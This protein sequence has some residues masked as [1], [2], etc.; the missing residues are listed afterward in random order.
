MSDL[1]HF[2]PLQSPPAAP[3]LL[4]SQTNNPMILE[5]YHWYSVFL[6]WLCPFS[7]SVVILLSFLQLS[8]LDGL[9]NLTTYCWICHS[10]RLDFYILCDF[11]A[12]T[13]PVSS[14]SRTTFSRG[15][16]HE[17]CIWTRWALASLMT[18]VKK[19]NK[20]AFS[21]ITCPTM[22]RVRIYDGRFLILFSL[23]ISN[24]LSIRPLDNCNPLC[25]M[26]VSIFSV[27]VI[28]IAFVGKH[29]CDFFPSILSVFGPH[30][31]RIPE[32]PVHGCN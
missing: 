5:K 9:I 27:R 3:S 28:Q 31:E 14:T 21:H 30:A 6:T 4:L 32:W 13:E 17:K 26:L 16:C 25:H 2:V 11:L 20:T 18:K 12:G 1:C 23:F 15:C 10:P 29:F 19:Q 7:G 8:R 22:E 24:K